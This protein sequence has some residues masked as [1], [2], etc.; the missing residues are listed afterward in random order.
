MATSKQ[1]T[2]FKR[3]TDQGTMRFHV[4]APGRAMECV[5]ETWK[6]TEQSHVTVGIWNSTSVGGKNH[7]GLLQF[8]CDSRGPTLR[9]MISK[10]NENLC[11]H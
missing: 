11:P 7:A 3:N 10:K 8:P 2:I 5:G 9:A 4:T 6:K 1:L